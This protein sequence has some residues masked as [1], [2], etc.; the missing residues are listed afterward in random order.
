[1]TGFD[2]EPT[3]LTNCHAWGLGGVPAGRRRVLDLALILFG[4]VRQAAFDAAIMS[5]ELPVS[6][7]SKVVRCPQATAQKPRDKI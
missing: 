6:C 4:P 3:W 7:A 1:M 2:P 5:G